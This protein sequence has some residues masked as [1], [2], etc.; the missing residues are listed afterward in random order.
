[1]QELTFWP[2]TCSPKCRY[3]GGKPPRRCAISAERR[4]FQRLPLAIPLFLRGRDKAGKEFLDFT[5][6]LDVSGGGAL[7]ATRRPLPK[8]TK[9]TLEVP[10][11]P[12]PAFIYSLQARRALEG[13]VIRSVSRDTYNLCAVRFTRPLLQAA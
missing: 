2:S 13:R 10:T 12:L 7:V 6:A 1:M 11:A 3:F 8:A 4:R 5:L 9:L